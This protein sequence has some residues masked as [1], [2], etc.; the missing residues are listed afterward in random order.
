[1]TFRE[2][3]YQVKQMLVNRLNDFGLESANMNMGWTTM[4]S[5]EQNTRLTIDVPLN[6]V[7]SDA[8]L[9]TGT[10]ETSTYSRLN[11][12][13]VK[14]KVGNTVVDSTTTN[15]NGEYSFTQTPVQ[16]GNHSF[17]V[18]FEGTNIYAA[19]QSSVINRVIGKE[20]SVINLDIIPTA[21]INGSTIV[22]GTLK[23]DDAE[24]IKNATMKMSTT[25]GNTLTTTTNNYG[26]FSF[27]LTDI[28]DF[29][30]V[31]ITCYFE[32]DTYY[33]SST[34]TTPI[35]VY[36]EALELTSDKSIL[37]YADSDYATLTV[38]YKDEGDMNLGAGR[39]IDLYKLYEIDN[40][41]VTSDKQILSYVDEDSATI[42]AQ[43]KYGNKNVQI[44][45][46]P[47][48]FTVPSEVYSDMTSI[49][50]QTDSFSMSFKRASGD[51]LHIYSPIN[52]DFLYINIG[53]I[54]TNS[55]LT[56]SWDKSNIHFYINGVAANASRIYSPYSGD[57]T[58]EWAYSDLKIDGNAVIK[59]IQIDTSY[60]VNTD[61]TGKAT[62]TYDS[63]GFGD[64]NIG[65]S[66]TGVDGSFLTKTFVVSD[67]IAYHSDE[68]TITSPTYPFDDFTFD[69]SSPIEIT[70]DYNSNIGSSVLIRHTTGFGFGII[71]ETGYKEFGYS[72]NGWHNQKH[73]NIGSGYNSYKYVINGNTV[74][75]HLNGALQTSQT[76]SQIST[77]TGWQFYCSKWSGTSCSIKNISIK[78]L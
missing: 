33:S 28:P 32:G 70:F 35:G 43:L 20:T 74:E 53:D 69:L 61:N 51:M 78:P 47:I 72:Q 73:I 9:I 7:Y 65:A 71:S 10:L 50:T 77:L 6:L 60:V 25:S 13:T 56:L 46:E 62:L 30:N 12:K 57:N 14:L 48:T 52:D 22:A 59:N 37:S 38:Q 26:Q 15:I 76:Y 68:I 75:Y 67:R 8:F 4:L 42:T 64:I 29:N 54:N 55:Q 40:I 21:H 45:N 1:M 3:F 49:P 19:S 36:Q 24:L 66:I 23:S 44:A 2:S 41:E 18:I 63:Q 34:I 58:T 31:S 27:T 16:T 11:G 5:I 17:Q 39:K